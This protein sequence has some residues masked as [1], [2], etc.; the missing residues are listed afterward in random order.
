MF[1]QIH[2]VMTTSTPARS[3]GF[4][5]TLRILS[6]FKRFLYRNRGRITLVFSGVTL[7]SLQI[8]ACIQLYPK[9]HPA[10]P[11]SSNIVF[12]TIVVL[13]TSFALWMLCV[14]LPLD[15]I[16]STRFDFLG[17]LCAPTL[18]VTFTTV[19]FALY[20]SVFSVNRDMHHGKE[21][22][23]IIDGTPITSAYPIWIN[24]FV[25]IPDIQPVPMDWSVKNIVCTGKT[26]EGIPVQG[27]VSVSLRRSPE[28]SQWKGF[29]SGQSEII[30]V[31]KKS[32]EVACSKES[33]SS[34][35]S[36]EGGF[37]IAAK[38]FLDGQLQQNLPKSVVLDGSITVNEFKVY[39]HDARH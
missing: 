9:I 25:R 26:A 6:N 32:F 16:S 38:M 36:R 13:V 14:K 37:S 34:Q 1:F 18:F 11:D 2:S 17:G 39:V 10:P 33:S 28:P 35:I 8:F 27:L 7:L 23:L 22:A 12:M 15:T 4:D 29:V 3:G 19:S 24:P 30:A 31:I 5:L 21:T 20:F